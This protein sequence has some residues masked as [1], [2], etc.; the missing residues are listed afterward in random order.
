VKD[1]EGDASEISPKNFKNS[2]NSSIS[3]DINAVRRD[4]QNLNKNVDTHT[5]FPQILFCIILFLVI[6]FKIKM[7]I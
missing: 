5:Y 1:F 7:N 6:F 3:I 2:F 4:L